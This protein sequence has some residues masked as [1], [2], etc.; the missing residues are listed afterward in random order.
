MWHSIPSLRVFSKTCVLSANTGDGLRLERFAR[1]RTKAPCKACGLWTMH[2]AHRLLARHSGSESCCYWNC[3]VPPFQL[4]KNQMPAAAIN[5][6]RRADLELKPCIGIAWIQN[7]LW[8]WMQMLRWHSGVHSW[9]CL[10]QGVLVIK[11]QDQ[12]LGDLLSIP[13]SAPD[14]L[15]DPG[16]VI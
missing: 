9:S 2:A 10:T 11:T 3:S 5:K 12:N 15:W 7:W 4:E 13:V 8:H 14:C 16:Q 1:D 6:E